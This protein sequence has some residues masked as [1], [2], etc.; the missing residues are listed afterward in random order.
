MRIGK[1]YISMFLGVALSAVIAGGVAQAG[2]IQGTKIK[3]DHPSPFHITL[4]PDGK[5]MF[6]ANQSGHSV[7]IIDTKSEKILG[8]I[9]V[10][11]QPEACVVSL[12]GKTL[13]VCNAE[14]DSVSVIDIAAQKVTK[15]IKVGDWPCSVKLSKDGKIAYVC[16]SGNMW[17][18]I[19]MIDTTKNEKIGE[20]TTTEYGPRD[21]AISPDGKTGVVVLDTAGKANRSVDFIDLTTNKVTENRI[22][23]ESANLRGIAYTP[24]GCYVIVTYETPKIWLPVCEAENGQIFTNNIAVIETKAGGKVARLPIDEL[25]DY[26]GNPYGIAV[27]PQGKYVYIGVRAMHRITILDLPKL[28]TVVTSNTQEELDFLR[29][30]FE[31]TTLYLVQR[32]NVGLCPSAVAVS[33]DGKYCYTNNYFSNSISVIQAPN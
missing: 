4:S 33:P 8:V 16:C 32:V 7:T 21:I 12:D 25:N 31:T 30:D 6:T 13:Y 2:F 22:I 3:T 26:D 27:D 17:K 19:D 9:P 29:D 24:C 20:I 10:G 15:E 11:V 28:I 1:K 5:T 14:S 18:S 23:G